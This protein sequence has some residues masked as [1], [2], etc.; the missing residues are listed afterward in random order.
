MGK[1]N[2]TI[3]FSQYVF[4]DDRALSIASFFVALENGVVLH[5]PGM[6]EGYNR[7]KLRVG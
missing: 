4:S 1:Q 3:L 5:E 7:N 2:T 6:R